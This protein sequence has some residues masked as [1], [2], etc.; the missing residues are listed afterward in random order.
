[1]RRTIVLLL[2][3]GVAAT[4]VLVFFGDRYSAEEAEATLELVRGEG[5]VRAGYAPS[6]PLAY[7]DATRGLT[8]EGP[9]IARE[10]FE[11]MGVAHLAGVST[12]P[13]A[14]IPGLYGRRYELITGMAIT[15]ENCREVRFSKPTHALGQ[16]FLVRRDNPLDLHSYEDAARNPEAYVGVVAG[17][18]Q[19]DYAINAGLPIGRIRIVTAP[20]AGVAALNSGVIDAFASDALT[21]QLLADQAPNEP[22]ERALPFRGPS[23]G[24][25]ELRRYG[26]FAFRRS[27]VG[28]VREFNRHLEELLG[29]PEHLDLVR[30]FGITEADLPPD[31]V[32]VEAL[33]RGTDRTAALAPER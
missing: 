31:D 23:I 13:D 15:P 26:A 19:H 17:S 25:R 11:R 16:A 6:A 4:I 20:A 2:G 18:V 12:E 5:M 24:G 32:T 14:L 1:M 33:C 30:P 9:A 8:G 28:L 7:A 10:V 22:I 21:V 29:T 27:D 3:L